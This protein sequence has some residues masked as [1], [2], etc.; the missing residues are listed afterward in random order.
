MQLEKCIYPRIISVNK[1]VGCIR[2]HRVCCT[3]RV[4]HRWAL[5]L[6]CWGRLL[7]NGSNYSELFYVLV[8]DCTPME[9]RWRMHVVRVNKGAEVEARCGG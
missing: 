9:W 4:E 2:M 3:V 1:D 7:E 8:H 6:N 5:A